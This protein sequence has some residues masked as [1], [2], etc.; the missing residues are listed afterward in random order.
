MFNE[1]NHILEQDYILPDDYVEESDT[2]ADDETEPEVASEPTEEAK[3]F[4]WS[5]LEFK[6]LKDTKKLGDLTPDEVKEL[7]QKGFNHDR[8]AEQKKGFEDQVNKLKGYE[9]VAKLY[10][11]EPQEF[12]G[13]LTNNHYRAIA[14][15]NGTSEEFERRAHD[16]ALKE[17]RIADFERTQ[18]EKESQTKQIEEFVSKFPEVDASTLPQ[19]VYDQALKGLSL[20]Q[21]YINY[22]NKQLKAELDRMKKIIDNTKSAPVT[23]TTGNGGDSSQYEDDFLSGLLGG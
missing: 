2:L 14:E 17:Q 3:P 13:E 12:I 18:S 7:V 11:Y 8:I 19:E 6:Y 21:A 15:R 23:A 16:I 20:E 1:D 4:D 5:S 9:D 10:G 22:Q